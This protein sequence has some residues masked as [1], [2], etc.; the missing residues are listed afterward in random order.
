[1]HCRATRFHPYSEA[2]QFSSL[3]PC[4]VFHRPRLN[5]DL[6]LALAPFNRRWRTL[7]RGAHSIAFCAV[8]W[9]NDVQEWRLGIT[10]SVIL[11][12]DAH[13]LEELI[14]EFNDVLWS[15]LQR[16]IKLG[17]NPFVEVLYPGLS[18]R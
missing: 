5:A 16:V 8:E 2:S 4:A 6:W 15:D 17:A 9:G 13:P 14:L 7:A 10:L 3:L 11:H 12:L 1:M 18:Q